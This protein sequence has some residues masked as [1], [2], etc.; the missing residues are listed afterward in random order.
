MTRSSKRDV[1]IFEFVN[2]RLRIGDEP[3][4]HL[5]RISAT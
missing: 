2:S 4:R 1:A 5:R 3:H